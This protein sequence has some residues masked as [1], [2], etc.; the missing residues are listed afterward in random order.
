LEKRKSIC[1]G[2]FNRPKGEGISPGNTRND[3][4]DPKAFGRGKKIETIV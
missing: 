3:F 4:E 1:G 2:S